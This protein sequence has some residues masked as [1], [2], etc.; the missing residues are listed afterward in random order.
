MD[1]KKRRLILS[2]NN[3]KQEPTRTKKIIDNPLSITEDEESIKLT[4][5]TAAADMN[6]YFNQVK[7]Q[8]T[9]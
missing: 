2:R 5:S 1:D 3:N 4:G 8:N 6:F 9:E 7:I